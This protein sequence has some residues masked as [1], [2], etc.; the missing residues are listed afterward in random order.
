MLQHSAN[1][2]VWGDIDV[3]AMPV[4]EGDIDAD[5]C[6]IGLGGSRLSAVD[7]ALVLEKRVVGID[8]GRIA[9][10]A[11]GRNGGLLL[12][13]L[14]DPYHTVVQ[15]IGRARAREIYA[16]TERDRENGSGNS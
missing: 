6:I 15:S 16:L 1:P 14:A 12:A 10:G 9:N 11:A 8:A 2:S 4:L 7:Q 13:G 3:P 5:V